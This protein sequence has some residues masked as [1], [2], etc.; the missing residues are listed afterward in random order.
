MYDV[1]IM[2]AGPAGLTAAIY[3]SRAGF[4]TL[5]LESPNITSQASMAYWIE[6]YPGFKEGISGLELTQLLKAQAQVFG[7][8]IVAGAVN[9]IESYKKDNRDIWQVK[10][11]KEY[12]TLSIII[13]SGAT[14]SRL[15]IAGEER[16]HGKGVSYCATCDGPLFKDKDIVMVGGGNSAVE[17][18][19]FLTKFCSK[20]K[21]IHRRNRLRATKVLQDRALSNKRIEVLWNAVVSEILGKEKVEAVKIRDIST[22][23]DR[24]IACEGVF[25]SIGSK[26][27]T[28][29]VKNVVKLD[30]EGCIVSDSMMK[31]SKESIFACGDCR[32]T[33]LRQVVTACGDGAFAAYSC[34]QYVDEIK[35]TSY[36]RGKK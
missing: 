27:N 31:T 24:E 2:G 21:L 18:A 9:T 32:N 15:G 30:K 7:A 36:E 12:E 29:F 26:P 11:D 22:D 1:V 23:K 20:V 6:N 19:L 8:E 25:I 33:P 28:D 16:L 10:A 13:A 14:A 34:Q 17:E 4:K 35:G 5:V 3:T